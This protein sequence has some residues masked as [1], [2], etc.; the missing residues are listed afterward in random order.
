MPCHGKPCPAPPGLALPGPDRRE[1]REGQS[2]PSVVELTKPTTPPSDPFRRSLPSQR[3]AMRTV[4]LQRPAAASPIL[5][6]GGP[7]SGTAM[8]SDPCP[9][10]PNIAL[11]CPAGPSAPPCHGVLALPRPALTC[12]ASPSQTS[13]GIAK[14]VQ[15]EP[16]LA[17]PDGKPFHAPPR[18]PRPAQQCG[19]GRC[20]GPEWIIAPPRCPSTPAYPS[21]AWHRPESPPPNR[22]PSQASE[23]MPRQACPSPTLPRN[24]T[25]RRSVPRYPR[26]GR[27]LPR[28][29]PS[30]PSSQP[31]CRCRRLAAPCR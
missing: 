14:T 10:A 15:A 6:D 26:H 23:S 12:S 22:M 8:V 18:C 9:A 29:A 1:Y 28:H 2:N 4:G 24:S 3:H 21:Q 30:R 19:S 11:P 25:D 7:C 17:T 16:R 13:H 31:R 27:A 20:C 5:S